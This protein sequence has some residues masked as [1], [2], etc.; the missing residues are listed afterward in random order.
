MCRI[1]IDN[2]AIMGYAVHTNATLAL[3]NAQEYADAAREK[4]YLEEA[5]SY[6]NKYLILSETA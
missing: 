2:D 3:S 6:F 1:S 5:V 4:S